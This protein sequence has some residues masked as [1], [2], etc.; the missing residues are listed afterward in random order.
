MNE[1]FKLS[2][3]VCLFAQMKPM[4]LSRLL[5]KI[6]SLLDLLDNSALS[7]QPPQPAELQYVY[8]SLCA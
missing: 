3:L 2:K 5:T 6:V 8:V 1:W 7:N 4:T